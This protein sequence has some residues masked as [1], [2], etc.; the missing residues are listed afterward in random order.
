ML[1]PRPYGHA[2]ALAR[3]RCLSLALILGPTQCWA[4]VREL[5]RE[6]LGRA[7]RRALRWTRAQAHPGTHGAHQHVRNLLH[8]V[9]HCRSCTFLNVAMDLCDR[10]AKEVC[11]EVIIN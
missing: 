7:Q 10:S 9:D 5:H 6:A 3:G 2:L 8:C 11:L 1:N 4:Q